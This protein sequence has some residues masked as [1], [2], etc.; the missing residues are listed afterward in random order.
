[1]E[2]KVKIR[3]YNEGDCKQLEDIFYTVRREEFF[4]VD[5]EKL[6]P[7]DFQ[8]TTEGEQIFVAEEDGKAVGFI[9]VW[10]PDKFI[11]NLFVSQMF[12]KQGIGRALIER[13]MEEFGTP[14]SLKCMKE[15]ESAL[16]FYRADGW[17]I[18]EEGM[19]E[20]GKYYLLQ[21]GERM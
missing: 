5:R 17:K 6:S 1:M 15:N 7:L 21:K 18:K 10:V 16:K 11:H 20:E 9:S 2:I 14:L 3:I 19:C 4:W 13:A 12:R 8:G